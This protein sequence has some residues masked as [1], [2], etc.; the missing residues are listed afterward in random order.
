MSPLAA[1]L[2]TRQDIQ[3]SKENRRHRL[4]HGLAILLGVYLPFYLGEGI[5]DVLAMEAVIATFNALAMDAPQINRII[6]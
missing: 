3:I 4:P 6:S 2:C 5:V 1:C